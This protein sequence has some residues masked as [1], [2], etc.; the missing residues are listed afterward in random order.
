MT[1]FKREHIT[2]SRTSRLFGKKMFLY[3]R[4]TEFGFGFNRKAGPIM[5]REHYERTDPA[6]ELELRFH[7]KV[8]WWHRKIYKYQYELVYHEDISQKVDELSKL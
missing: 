7:F 8:L 3:E 6:N 2:I 1:D 4:P 5:Y